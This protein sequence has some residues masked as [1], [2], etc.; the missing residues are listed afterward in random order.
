VLP[1]VRAFSAG[2]EMAFHNSM[3]KQEILI[4][5][6]PASPVQHISVLPG[7]QHLTTFQRATTD[8]VFKVEYSRS[9][10]Y[11]KVSAPISIFVHGYCMIPSA[12]ISYS[13]K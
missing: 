5:L 11:Y 4:F 13:V 2:V 7:F 3:S 8:Y 9:I 10:L 6:K 12:C 1:P